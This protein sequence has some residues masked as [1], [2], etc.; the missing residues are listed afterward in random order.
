MKTIEVSLSAVDIN[1]ACRELDEYLSQLQQKA[2]ELRRRV[3]D[4]IAANTNFSQCLIRMWTYANQNGS[5]VAVD[6]SRSADVQVQ[7]RDDGTVSTVLAVGEDAV[8]CEFGTG[9]HYNN[10]LGKSPHDWGEGLGF[11]I[12]GYGKGYGKNKV[13]AWREGE[14]IFTRGIPAYMPLY[15]AVQIVVSRIGDIAKEVFA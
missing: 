1:R 6:V 13:W 7:I 8:W 3:A 4:E 12:G 11:I 14:L 2:E 10:T 15:N 5:R 9:V